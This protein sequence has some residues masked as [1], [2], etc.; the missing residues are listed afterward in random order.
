M[1]GDARGPRLAL[2]VGLPRSGKS[3]YARA[4]QEVGWVRIEPDAFRKALHGGAFFSPAEPIVW[5]SAELAVRALLLGGHAVL[6][7]ATNTTRRRRSGWIRIAR[8]V[9]APVE[10]FVMTTTAEECRRRNLSRRHR[11]PEEVMDRMARQ[12]EPI[13]PEE[14]PKVTPIESNES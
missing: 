10:A 12:W 3:T 14:I 13:A 1:D 6:V 11:V 7:D 5:A 9:G 2:M 8:D 4:L